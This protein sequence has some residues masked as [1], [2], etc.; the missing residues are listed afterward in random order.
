MTTARGKFYLLRGSKC[1]ILAAEISGSVGDFSLLLRHVCVCVCVSE[2]R[3]VGTYAHIN[4]T[5]HIQ[6]LSQLGRLKSGSLHGARVGQCQFVLGSMVNFF[7]EAKHKFTENCD[8]RNQSCSTVVAKPLLLLWPRSLE[9]S[10]S[11]LPIMGLVIL[12]D[13]FGSPKI[14]T[15]R[16]VPC[17]S[18]IDSAQ[19]DHANIV[20]AMLAN[21][22]VQGNDSAV[23]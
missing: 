6:H 18:A 11:L 10:V 14:I 4:F 5:R 2:L 21:K 13:S 7:C 9:S 22:E 15:R 1:G 16:H 3:F 20:H 12:V 8:L 17:R 23:D 19:N